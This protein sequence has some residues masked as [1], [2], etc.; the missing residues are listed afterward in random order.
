MCS[1]RNPLRASPD[2]AGGGPTAR[3]FRTGGGR[4]PDREAK[5]PPSPPPDTP[6]R[7]GHNSRTSCRRGYLPEWEA[8]SRGAPFD[9]RSGPEF[10]ELPVRLDRLSL[11]VLCQLFEDG[12]RAARRMGRGLAKQGRRLASRL[13]GDLPRLRERNLLLERVAGS[14]AVWTIV[15]HR[16]R[17]GD[18][19]AHVALDLRDD[20]DR[21]DAR[22]H[23]GVLHP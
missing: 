10:R 16:L 23:R 17:F 6:G 3:A 1:A 5:R 11:F 4:T 7:R 8:S 14:A 13:R 20:V 21:I 9:H 18:E 22:H 12:L 19:T 15:R 2:G